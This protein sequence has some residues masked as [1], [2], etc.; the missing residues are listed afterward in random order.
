LRRI[1]REAFVPSGVSQL[2]DAITAE[3]ER[4][5][6]NVAA[7]GSCDFASEVAAVYPVGIVCRILGI[8]LVDGP[9][10]LEL[11]TRALG[12]GDSEVGGWDDSYDAALE[13]IDYGISLARQRRKVA[14][15]DLVTALVYA[16]V[17]G[18]RLDDDE[19]GS[20]F[21]LLVTAGIET[22]GTAVAQGLRVL[23]EHPD[24]LRTWRDDASLTPT[25]VDE[26]VR[27]VTPVIHFRRTA[28][29]DV[30]L[31]DVVVREGDKVVLW[32]LAAN[33]DERVFTDADVFDVARMPNDH[34]G[35]G[36]GGHH[37]CLGAHLAR[38]EIAALFHELFRQL[39]EIEVTG[40]PVRLTSMFVNG[41][42]SLPIR[43]SPPGGSSSTR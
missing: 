41:L 40:E 29:R 4:V 27:W 6:G 15:D 26:I 12:F 2:N 39:G 13:L 10:L 28:T 24:Q 9:A 16:E 11:T 8:P 38:A 18:E 43:W 5:V 20:F 21:E 30:R 22:T 31:G 14:S 34:V 37:F 35:F 33:R 17:E 23:C 19:I 1:V 42:R 25:A 3:A 32:Y 36:A 7:H